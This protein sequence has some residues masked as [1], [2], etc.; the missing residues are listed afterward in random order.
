MDFQLFCCFE[1]VCIVLKWLRLGFD[2]GFDGGWTSYRS[3]KVN[4]QATKWF[5]NKWDKILCHLLSHK[6]KPTKSKIFIQ[7]DWL[8]FCMNMEGFWILF[9]MHEK[10]KYFFCDKGVSSNPL[11]SLSYR[12]K[13]VNSLSVLFFSVNMHYLGCVCLLM[14]WTVFICLLEKIFL[15]ICNLGIITIVIICLLSQVTDVWLK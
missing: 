1:N 9:V 10:A 3:L 7:C 13:R 2:Q 11:K 5:L 4:K 8:K 12:H 6:T 15:L 14:A